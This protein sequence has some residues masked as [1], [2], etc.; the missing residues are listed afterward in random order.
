MSRSMVARAVRYFGVSAGQLQ[1][2]LE[3]NV[4]RSVFRFG[5][6]LRQS[7]WIGCGT[8]RNEMDWG[9][10]ES[11]LTGACPR[12]TFCESKRIPKK[13]VIENRRDGQL[14]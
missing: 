6:P 8:A 7:K 11:C 9:A 14:W 4:T 1:A 10:R 12:A 2:A 5:V 13:D 3:G